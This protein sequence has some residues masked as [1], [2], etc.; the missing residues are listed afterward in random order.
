VY[1][2]VLGVVGNAVSEVDAQDGH[3]VCPVVTGAP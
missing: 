2:W 3:G 1:R